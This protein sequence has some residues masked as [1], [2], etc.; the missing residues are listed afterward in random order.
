MAIRIERPEADEQIE[1][2]AEILREVEG[3]RLDVDE[4]R[5]SFEQ[6][7]ES[8]WG[9]AYVDGVP[10]GLA[11]GRPSSLPGSVYGAA[12]VLP[13]LRRRGVGTALVAAIGASGGAGAP[14]PGISGAGPAPTTR[15][16]SPS[17]STAGST[18]SD[19]NGTSCST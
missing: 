18:R 19:G 10:S 6:D 2:W 17:P 15:R 5:H 16:R 8:Y 1:A 14:A 3:L 9:L 11:V 12:R 13:A 4:L 7:R